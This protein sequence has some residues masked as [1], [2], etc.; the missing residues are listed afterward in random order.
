MRRSS[1]RVLDEV[2]G[3]P[4]RDNVKAHRLLSD[5]KYMPVTSEGPPVRAQQQL[6]E[7][8]RRGA[9]AP[10]ETVLRH[11]AAPEVVE[12]VPAGRISA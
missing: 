7:I 12:S 4:L 11:A 3:V 2:L 6:L 5:G 1:A 8:A 9:E 10:I